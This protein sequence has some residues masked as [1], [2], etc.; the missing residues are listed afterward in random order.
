MEISLV[1]VFTRFKLKVGFRYDEVI[2]VRR[3]RNFSA[4]KAVA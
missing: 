4:V 1:N 3:S 2:A